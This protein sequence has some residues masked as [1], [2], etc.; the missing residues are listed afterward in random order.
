MGSG[1]EKRY[2]EAS[3]YNWIYLKS[4]MI[5]IIIPWGQDVLLGVIRGVLRERISCMLQGLT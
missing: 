5:G 4:R 3:V 2:F 1:I